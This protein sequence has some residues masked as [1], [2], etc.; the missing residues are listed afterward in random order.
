MLLGQEAILK[1]GPFKKSLVTIASMPKNDRI[2]VFIHI[3][4]TKR[5]ATVSLAE[6]RL[7]T[8]KKTI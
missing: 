1:D 8:L 7:N 6:V 5:R 3:L 2:D 4:G